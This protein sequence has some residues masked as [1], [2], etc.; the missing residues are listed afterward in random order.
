VEGFVM[1]LVEKIAAK[2]KVIGEIV[3][4]RAR[5]RP[6]HHMM[7]VERMIH[8]TVCDARRVSASAIT[9]SETLLNRRGHLEAKQLSQF[10]RIPECSEIP[11]YLQF[12]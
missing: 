8:C 6:W 10:F 1:I 4:Q 11:V 3:L 7:H 9:L 2:I 12:F 5:L